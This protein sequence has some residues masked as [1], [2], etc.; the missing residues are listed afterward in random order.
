MNA[1]RPR[2]EH[3]LGTAISK[4]LRPSLRGKIQ[5][6]AGGMLVGICGPTS[7]ADD[8]SKAVGMID[9]ELKNQVG[10]VEIYEE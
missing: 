4:T 3:I 2:I 8:V 7:L 10:G 5:E 6:R 9:S 1:G